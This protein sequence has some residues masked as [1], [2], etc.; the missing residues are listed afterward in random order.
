MQDSGSAANADPVH[1]LSLFEAF[2]GAIITFLTDNNSEASAFLLLDSS[3]ACCFWCCCDCAFRC[4]F[5]RQIWFVLFQLLLLV[6]E[7]CA[8]YSDGCASGCG[9]AHTGA[10]C[11][12]SVVLSCKS[13]GAA[14]MGAMGS[15]F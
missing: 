6:I 14:A 7:G 13:G 4:E 5:V 2:T 10:A 8:V 11:P 3:V 12:T 9:G 15:A 1:I